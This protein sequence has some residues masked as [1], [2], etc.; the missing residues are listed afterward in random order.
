MNLE[1]LQS[2]VGDSPKE[3]RE[4]LELFLGASGPVLEDLYRGLGEKSPSAVKSAAHTLKGSAVS[5]GADEVAELARCLE[6]SANQQTWAIAES[7]RE[8]LDAALGRVASVAG[9]L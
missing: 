1:Q 5:V 4:Y 3:W 9:G 8:R 7:I 6:V 2:L